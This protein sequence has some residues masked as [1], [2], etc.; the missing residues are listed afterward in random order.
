LD[1]TLSEVIRILEYQMTF[2]DW[3]RSGPCL[4]YYKEWRGFILEEE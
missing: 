1:T 3:Y 2:R 4:V